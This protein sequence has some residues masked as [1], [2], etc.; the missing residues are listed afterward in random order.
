MI[1]CEYGTYT[2]GGFE[3]S[4]AV[5]T[6]VFV[7]EQGIPFDEEEDAFDKTSLFAIA[8]DDRDRP[9][10]CGRLFTDE[11][12]VYHIG[13]VAV[14]K[15]CRNRGAG[16]AV[17]RM[18]LRR[19]LDSGAAAVRISAQLDKTGFY[20][21]YGFVPSGDVYDDTGIPHIRMDVNA[22]DVIL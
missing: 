20:A 2:D 12:G 11:D 7:R 16:D 3:K 13:R 22:Q 9:I 21:R 6:E 14:L 4:M 5:R 19:A 18:L 1:R 15:E 8:L 10:G 17:M